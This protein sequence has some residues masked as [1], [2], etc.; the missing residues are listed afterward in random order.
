M[1]L[2]EPLYA[3]FPEAEHQFEPLV[4]GEGEDGLPVLFS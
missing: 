3:L 1:G 4:I 2:T